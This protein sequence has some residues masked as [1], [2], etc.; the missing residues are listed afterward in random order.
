VLERRLSEKV[1][2]CDMQ[3]GFRP[4]KGTID[5]ILTSR[6]MQEKLGNKGKKL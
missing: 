5:A 3:F 6:Q 4:G 1:N 2:T